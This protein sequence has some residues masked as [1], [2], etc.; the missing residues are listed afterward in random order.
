[1]LGFRGRIIGLYRHF[2]R[3]KMS[4]FIRAGDGPGLR[5]G[6]SSA[7]IVNEAREP[8]GYQL[9]KFIVIAAGLRHCCCSSHEPALLRYARLL[10]QVAPLVFADGVFA[11]NGDTPINLFIR[12]QHL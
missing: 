10:T 8:W 7:S 5:G 1:M 12:E 9:G 2:Y 3:Q 6:H 11:L 4:A